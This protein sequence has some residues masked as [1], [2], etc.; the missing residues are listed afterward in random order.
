M[1]SQPSKSDEGVRLNKFLASCGL[2]SRRGCEN[3]I[4]AGQIQVNGK[5]CKNLA[6]RI[7]PGDS[8][9][10]NGMM[11][12]Q[13]R[14]TTILLNKPKGFLSSRGDPQG[15]DTIYN[16]LPPSFH[17][18]PHIGRLDLDSHGL[19]LL[20]NASELSELLSHPKHKIEKEYHVTLNQTFDHDH[21]DRMKRGIKLE[22]GLAK[23]VS[24]KPL[25]K[26]RVSVI[27]TQGYKRQ[28]RNMFDN[29]GYR[30]KNLER[31][32]IGNLMAY[33]LM[34]GKWKLLDDVEIKAA[35][36]LNNLPQKTKRKRPR[37]KI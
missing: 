31:I 7:V 20:S 4:E 25:S 17:H 3:L 12:Q 23:A 21:I 24:V 18:L 15:R 35:M 9:R 16:L 10:H 5:L 2:G 33:D 28:I 19:I 13:A 11:L 29:I 26:R 32:R 27:L 22:D 6:T 14:E 34:P 1:P 37:K 30:V 36:M 8:V